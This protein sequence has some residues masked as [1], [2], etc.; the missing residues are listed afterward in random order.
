MMGLRVERI[1]PGAPETV[2]GHY[3]DRARSL[4][5][6]NLRADKKVAARAGLAPAPFRL[7]SGRTTVI[8]PGKK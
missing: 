2:P 5:A 7:T 8:P 4:P 1:Y 3:F 6:A